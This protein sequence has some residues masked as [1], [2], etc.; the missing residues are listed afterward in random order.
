MTQRRRKR[1]SRRVGAFEDRFVLTEAQAAEILGI[2]QRKLAS[3]RQKFAGP[4]FSHV[5][6]QIRYCPKDLLDFMDEQRADAAGA[7]NF[8]D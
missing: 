7:Q 1:L 4:L 5:G 2:T 3:M 8:E 6:R